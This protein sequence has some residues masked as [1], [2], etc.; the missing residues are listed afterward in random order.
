MAQPTSSIESEP[1]MR[2][3]NLSLTL[4]LS[5]AIGLAAG[6]VMG[7]AR[8]A[9]AM[10][11]DNATT[12]AEMNQC[13]QEAYKA[14]DAELNTAYD[15]LMGRLKKDPARAENLRRAQR[16]WIGFRDAECAFVS[17]G[18]TGGTAQPLVTAQCLEQQTRRRV[19]TLESYMQCEEGDLSCP[20]T[21][22]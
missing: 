5:F 20:T 21:P 7:S 14:T 1:G 10:P 4:A 8:A 9:T 17:A 6:A 16:A 18:T 22:Q 15:K 2:E 13:S 19:E 12:Q 11:C 3:R